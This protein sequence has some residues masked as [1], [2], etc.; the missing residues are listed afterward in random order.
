MTPPNLISP[1]PPFTVDQFARFWAA[2]DS[3]LIVGEMFTPDVV[4]DW[5]GDPEPVRGFAAYRA[6]VA[7]LLEHSLGAEA[8]R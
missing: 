1:P 2:P 3:A 6:R 5:P 7:R 4:G 8:H